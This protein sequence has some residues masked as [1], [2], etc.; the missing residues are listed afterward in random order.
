[1]QSPARILFVPVSG[2]SGMGEF[3]RARSLADALRAR[4]PHI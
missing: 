2:P 1:M 4:W 3:A